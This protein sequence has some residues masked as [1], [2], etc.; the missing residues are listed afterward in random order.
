MNK[1]FRLFFLL[2][3]AWGGLTTS[4]Q[5]LN[6][7]KKWYE[8]GDYEKAKPVFARFVKSYPNNGNY[9]LWYGVCCLKTGDAAGAIP[10]LEKAVKRRTPSGQ[11]YLGQAYNGQYRYEEAI[12]TFEA[13]ITDLAKRKR[14]TAEADSLLAISRLG[15][16]LLRGVEEVQVIDSFVVDRRN[17]PVLNRAHWPLTKIISTKKT[18]KAGRFMK[19]N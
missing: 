8:E 6:Q 16:R 4:A 9:N 18:E 17:F 7:A 15:L 3:F 5:T 10:P 19:T 11:L 12:E 2:A 14:S 13:Y 1:I